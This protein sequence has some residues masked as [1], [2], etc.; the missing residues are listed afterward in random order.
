MFDKNRFYGKTIYKCKKGKT[1]LQLEII[2]EQ[3]N[4]NVCLKI[5]SPKPMQPK[6]QYVHQSMYL[7]CGFLKPG[8]KFNQK[9]LHN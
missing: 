7:E 4:W 6:C 8:S 1:V 5:F 2:I 3:L 9:T